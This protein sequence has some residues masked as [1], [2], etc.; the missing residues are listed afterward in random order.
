M[1][2][3]GG[4]AGERGGDGGVRRG[5]GGDEVGDVVGVGASDEGVDVPGAVGKLG[6]ED[7]VG[8][9]AVEGDGGRGFEDGRVGAADEGG[10]LERVGEK[11]LVEGGVGAAGGVE[12]ADVDVGEGRRADQLGFDGGRRLGREHGGAGGVDDGADDLRAGGARAD[13]DPHDEEIRFV[14]DGV[15]QQHGVRVADAKDQTEIGERAVHARGALGEADEDAVRGKFVA[16]VERGFLRVAEPDPI[17]LLGG[18]HFECGLLGFDERAEVE[19]AG[20]RDAGYG[21]RD[22]AARGRGGAFKGVHDGQAS[23]RGGE[24]DVGGI[25]EAVVAGD[26]DRRFAGG[27][28]LAGEADDVDVLWIGVV[29]RDAVRVGAG[30]DG[31]GVL[32]LDRG[33]R[34]EGVR[35]NGER[36]EPTREATGGCAYVHVRAFR[37]F[38][39]AAVDSRATTTGG[40]VRFW[41]GAPAICLS[42][43]RT[44]RAARSSSCP[45]TELSGTEQ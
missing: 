32:D 7:E 41:A 10:F 22:H 36:G 1:A 3:V 17:R 14:R 20:G 28:P 25:G 35:Q 16:G 12:A 18:E 34:G 23:R 33:G 19:R 13:F 37:F 21:T 39:E 38:G 27:C 11:Q 31:E 5:G 24:Q 2:G 26:E 6:G 42:R 29:D 43:M 15:G 8:L 44:A 45:D 30:G 40:S 4:E 9:L